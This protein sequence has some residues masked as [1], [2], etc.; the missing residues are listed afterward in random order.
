MLSVGGWNFGI[1]SA[2][3]MLL[4]NMLR[5]R[6]RRRQFVKTS[7]AFVRKRG[8]DGI[9]LDFEYPGFLKHGSPPSD[10]QKYTSLVKVS[11]SFTVHVQYITLHASLLASFLGDPGSVVSYTHSHS[12]TKV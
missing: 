9:D 10:K 5:T 6:L 4:T 7:I 11:F 2:T 8:F 1:K 12:D 3:K